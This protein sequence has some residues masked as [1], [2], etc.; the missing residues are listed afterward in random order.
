M[1]KR[2]PYQTRQRRAVLDCF[3]RR[4]DAQLSAAEVAELLD[5]G[6]V[7]AGRT[8]VYRTVAWLHQNG[9]LTSYRDARTPAGIKYSLRRQG[10]RHIRVVCS[11]CGSVAPLHCGEVEAFERHL[12][13]EHGFT[14]SQEDCVLPGLCSA[15][16]VS[17]QAELPE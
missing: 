13:R 3:T 1:P 9:L 8:T 16:S 5:K 6:G 7:P 14:L 10:E 4:P 12:S 2:T 11:G 17:A 15:C